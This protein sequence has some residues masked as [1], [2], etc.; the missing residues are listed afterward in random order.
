[1]KKTL[2]FALAIAMVFAAPVTAF[3]NAFRDSPSNVPAP[4]LTGYTVTPS[5]WTGEIIVTP[6]SRRDTLPKKE[7]GEEED[8]Y[9]SIRD[10]GNA[11]QLESHLAQIAARKHVDPQNLFVSDLFDVRATKEGMGSVTIT[12]K[13]D[14]F[15]NFVALLHFVNDQEWVVVDNASCDGT[16]LTF[17]VD[18][19]SPFAVVVSSEDSPPTGESNDLTTTGLL[20]LTVLSGAVGVGFLVKSRRE[21]A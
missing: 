11:V 1:M 5:D 8:A 12:L 4:E 19:L 10:A 13:S 16:T 3:A 17:T 15:R 2:M 7:L 14:R 9:N 21:A 18:E 20:A 6:Y